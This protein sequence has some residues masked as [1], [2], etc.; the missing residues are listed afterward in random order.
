[1]SSNTD[2]TIL[3]TDIFMHQNGRKLFVSVKQCHDHTPLMWHLSSRR[4]SPH[5]NLIK[6]IGEEWKIRVWRRSQTPTTLAELQQAFQEEWNNIPHAD[7]SSIIRS[8]RSRQ[9]QWWTQKK[10]I[11][12][13]H[14]VLCPLVC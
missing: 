13:S 14:F 12:S 3:A 7:T 2:D 1:M 6:H 4:T 11:F 9:C 10:F 5:L 8:M